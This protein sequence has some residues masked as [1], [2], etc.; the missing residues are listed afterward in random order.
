MISS[1]LVLVF[2]KFQTPFFF[3]FGRCFGQGAS[4]L[5]WHCWHPWILGTLEWRGRARRQCPNFRVVV[6][7]CQRVPVGIL[8]LIFK[9]AK[10]ATL[11]SW[12]P[13]ILASSDSGS[14]S[15]GGA[16]ATI[17]PASFLSS[18][19]SAARA[20]IRVRLKCQHPFAACSTLATAAYHL[21][22]RSLSHAS[23][24][25]T[26]EP[27]SAALR[28]HS[29]TVTGDGP[30]AT[31][32]RRLRVGCPT[33]RRAWRRYYL[34]TPST[35]LTSRVPSSFFGLVVFRSVCQHPRDTRNIVPGNWS[36][37]NHDAALWL[38]P[39]FET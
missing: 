11:R 36:C 29:S 22:S 38:S 19:L 34:T 9:D 5:S 18:Y 10:S 20:R 31:G 15:C 24:S 37:E 14:A 28:K 39:P 8:G 35:R 26:V 32:T 12:H 1:A 13:L 21:A 30:T 16:V 27:L 33:G 25:F 7:R 23:A 17:R 3:G 4:S 2:K 6:G